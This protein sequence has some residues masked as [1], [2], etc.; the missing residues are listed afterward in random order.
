MS[1]KENSNPHRHTYMMLS[2]LQRD[3]DYFLGA[4]GRSERHLWAGN[5]DAQI[6]EMKKMWNTLPEDGKPEWLSM[7]DILEYESNMKKDSK[8][9]SKG[10]GIKK[11]PIA[12]QR[13]IDEI[14][15]ML[16]KVLEADDIAGGYQGSTMY[17]YV[18]LK[19]PIEVKNHFVY[20]NAKAGT[21]NYPFEKRYNV[22]NRDDYSSNGRKALMHDLG[23]I[24]KAFKNLLSTKGSTYNDGGGVDDFNMDD[25]MKYAHGEISAFLGSSIK[26]K[27]TKDWNFKHEGKA[28]QVEP[29]VHYDKGSKK[30]MRTAYFT[31]YD[32]GKEVGVIDYYQDGFAN[33]KHFV[34]SSELFDWN[35]QRFSKGGSTYENGGGVGEKK[36]PPLN[37]VRVKFEDPKYNYSTNVAS[38]IDEEN[39][40][41]YFVGQSFN[42][43]SYPKE[44][45]EQVVDIEWEKGKHSNYSDGGEI[46]PIM[47]KRYGRKNYIEVRKLILEDLANAETLKELVE[48]ELEFNNWNSIRGGSGGVVDVE[49]AKK[50][51]FKQ[52]NKDYRG[53]LNKAKKELITQKKR[54]Y[55]NYDTGDYFEGG[56]VKSN[57]FSGE[58][59]FLNY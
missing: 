7:E 22:N 55:E 16:P 12:A 3:N 44:Q 43:G 53:N 6:D 48:L 19:K 27:L 18:E 20:L 1:D 35:G 4:G 37:I 13:R 57:W 29:I 25:F 39:A 56:S 24:K 32:N 21:N 54:G 33:G 15:E 45:F 36:Y 50:T 14:N 2:R 30:I 38:G 40:R 46:N 52:L 26:S 23:I 28:Y 5:V 51:L 41:A 9:Y 42:V 8:E 59:S 31:I 34:A 49:T 58:L 47:E 10:G 17:S 11:F